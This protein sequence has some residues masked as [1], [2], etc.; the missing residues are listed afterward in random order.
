MVGIDD[1]AAEGSNDGSALGMPVGVVD[2][3]DEGA[4]DGLLVGTELG[5]PLGAALGSKPSFI[6]PPHTQQAKSEFFPFDQTLTV[7]GQK[8][9]VS[10][11]HPYPR[12][13]SQT[14]VGS[15]THWVGD[16]LGSSELITVG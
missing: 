10:S 1:G 4:N 2:G 9:L 8:P 12:S 6:P 14:Y 11:A 16:S 13:L 15:S 5:V 3:W 7:F